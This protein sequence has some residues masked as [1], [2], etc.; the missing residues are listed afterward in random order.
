MTANSGNAG[1]TRSSATNSSSDQYPINSNPTVPIALLPD[2]GEIFLGG[3]EYPGTLGGYGIMVAAD[4]G[5]AGYGGN[6]LFG[7]GGAGAIANTNTNVSGSSGTFGAGGGG[8][9]QTSGN[10]VTTSGS[11]GAGVC[12]IT[13]YF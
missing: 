4:H 3:R 12:F 9:I 7:T 13:E 11:G 8:S 6:S 10:S 1:I 2:T 5:I